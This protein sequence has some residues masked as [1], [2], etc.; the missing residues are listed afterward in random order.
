MDKQV[1]IAIIG[2]GYWGEKLIGEYMKLSLKNSNI[3]IC[4][5]A[6][7]N[8]QRLIYVKDKYNLPD[9]VLFR[10]H[11]EVLNNDIV[12]AVHIAT[13]NETHYEIATEAI[14]KGKH[15]LLEKPMTM[16]SRSAFKLARKA[17]KAGKVLLI[18][19][20]FRFNNAINEAKHI[21]E[22]GE[23]GEVHYLD[24]RWTTYM[25]ELPERDIIFDL[26]PHPIDIINHL[27]EEWPTRIYSIAKSFKRK[28]PGFE[29]TAFIMMDLPGDKIAG[30]NLSWIQP[31]A[32]MR[33]VVIVGEKS[34]LYID[35]LNQK[36]YI[37]NNENER[38]KIK[39]EANN[40]I[41]SMISHFIDRIVNG[42]PP[43]NSPLIGAMTVH[44]LEKIRESIL[45]KLSVNIMAIP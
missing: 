45:Q 12:N 10:N 22:S 29:E 37:C 18:G 3:K 30:I 43:I 7:I 23:L 9:K 14:E 6:D 19:H 20:I 1:K 38:L 34:T 2:A 13:P 27:L 32:K 40:T 28:K 41:E 42:S 44:V 36:A 31:G 4:A 11:T 26:A 21:I 24:L 35:A 17:E 15:I 16:S 25:Q 33:E 5:I 39:V 8:P